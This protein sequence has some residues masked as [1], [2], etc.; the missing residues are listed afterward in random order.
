MV[1]ALRL[2]FDGGHGSEKFHKILAIAASKTIYFIH[3]KLQLRRAFP[4]FRWI[5]L[6]A[7]LQWATANEVCLVHDHDVT[8]YLDFVRR[9]NQ[10]FETDQKRAQSI[11]GDVHRFLARKEPGEMD[12][13]SILNIK[14][15]IRETEARSAAMNVGV[16][17]ERLHHLRL[18]FYE[19]GRNEAGFERFETDDGPGVSVHGESLGK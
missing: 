4:N 19:T 3:L 11:A 16:A 9:F 15:L 1:L 14:A 18:P 10:I 7:V 17:E 8:R 5:S 2:F 13:P 6:D 12:T